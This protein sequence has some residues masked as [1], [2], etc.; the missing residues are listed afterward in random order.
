MEDD[1]YMLMSRYEKKLMSVVMTAVII[2]SC[3]ALVPGYVKAA[4]SSEPQV[5]VLG[6]TL[7]L[8]DSDNSAEGR[9]S[10]RIGI[11]VAS[12]DKAS[13]CAIRLTVNGKSYT[14]ATS[15]AA[16]GDDTG[17]V[18]NKLHSINNEDNSVVYAVVLTN[19][20]YKHFYTPIEIKGRAITN[21]GTST[22]VNSDK[23]NRNVMGI[24]NSLQSKYPNLGININDNGTIVKSSGGALTAADLAGYSTDSPSDYETKQIDLNSFNAYGAYGSTSVAYNASTGITVNATG[25]SYFTLPID[26]CVPGDTI[27]VRIKGTIGEISKGFRVYPSRGDNGRMV[28]NADIELL[29]EPGTFDKT[30][31]YT[32]YDDEQKNTNATTL[33]IN[34]PA[35]DTALTDVTISSVEVTYKGGNPA[36][37]AVPTARPTPPAPATPAPDYDWTKINFDTLSVDKTTQYI[38]D[39]GSLVLNN[40]DY[41]EVPLTTAQPKETTIE[42]YITGISYTDTQ[43]FRVWSGQRNNSRTSNVITPNTGTYGTEFAHTIELKPQTKEDGNS[44]YDNV[45]EFSHFTICAK[46]DGKIDDLEITSLYYRV[47]SDTTASASLPDKFGGNST[48]VPDG[49]ADTNESV[50]GTVVDISYDST[51][52]TE[53]KTITRNAKVVLPKGY[54]TNDTN[55]KYPVLY[56]LHGLFGDEKTLYNDKTQYV[57]WNAIHAGT[58]TDMIVVFPNVCANEAGSGSGYNLEHYKAYDNFIND[59]IKCLMPYINNN[60]HT[61]TGRRNTAIAGFSMGGRE[62]LHIGFTRQDSFRYIGAFCPAFGIFEYSNYGVTESGLFKQKDFTISNDY[63]NDTLI[64]IAAGKND[65]IVKD[66][67]KRYSDALVNNGVPHLYYETDGRHDSSVY[68][69]GLYQF[70]TRIFK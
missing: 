42:V 9:Q 46:Y 54:D 55:T 39:S 68:K 67:P 16:K 52:I 26:T 35:Y 60:Y 22:T 24:V 53:G 11:R 32:I 28:K 34:G 44:D 57:I 64:I 18:H 30:L 4:D 15:D 19:I 48:N 56:M 12:A 23:E 47:I 13:D 63:I 37:T 27:V 49:F 38:T 43:E 3:F 8:A 62:S 5:S 2:L 36:P 69:H 59:L 25:L 1:T 50:A 61:L 41:I 21:D 45:T 31:T 7:R 29:E 10:M 51:A 40:A 6:A 14:V 66:E 65:D 20:P 17:Y 33:C 58:A 70:I